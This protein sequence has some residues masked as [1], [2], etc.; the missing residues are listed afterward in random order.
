MDSS[1]ANKPLP[2]ASI[3][4]ELIVAYRECSARGLVHSAHWYVC[5]CAF[6]RAFVSVCVRTR[7]HACTCLVC[8]GY[9]R[10]QYFA[11]V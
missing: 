2:L 7:V 5:F 4:Q 8:H 11:G 1:P 10:Q 6:V 9:N 3:K